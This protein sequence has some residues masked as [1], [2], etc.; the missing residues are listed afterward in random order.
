MTPARSAARA[1]RVAALTRLRSLVNDA[2]GEPTWR[3]LHE[4][5]FCGA[6]EAVEW[7]G[8]APL[9][10]VSARDDHRLHVIDV[11]AM[12]EAAAHNMNATGDAHVSFTAMDLAASPDASLLLVATDRHRC[13]LMQANSPLQVRNFYGVNN[14][15]YSNPRV[16][17]GIAGHHVY[18]TSQDQH[19][20]SA[21]ARA[22]RPSRPD[23]AARAECGGVRRGLGAPGAPADRPQQDGAR[24]AAAPLAR[25]AGDGLVR[26]DRAHLVAVSGAAD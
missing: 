13:L 20:R 3:R 17:W 14:D 22:P 8:D 26:R 21:R 23:A 15:S 12:R 19:V 10:V 25:A 18:C 11:A 6:V 7:L 9:C 2:G 24:H 16:A 1:E 5:V 4:F